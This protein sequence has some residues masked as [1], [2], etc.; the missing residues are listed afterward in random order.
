MLRV[1]NQPYIYHYTDKEG[2]AGILMTRR[3]QPLYPGG[4]SFFTDELYGDGAT[5]YRRLG[6]SGKAVEICFAIPRN[7]I[8]G[9]AG[10]RP[11]RPASYPPQG[12]AA[13]S[14]MG[15]EYYSAWPVH[16]SNDVELDMRSVG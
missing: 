9:L 1:M 12:G 10:P 3:I 15:N 4:V 8:S 6:I 2:A 11:A 5:A 16:L 14:G 13:S 7:R